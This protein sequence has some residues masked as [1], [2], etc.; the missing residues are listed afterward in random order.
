M[1]SSI[2]RSWPRASSSAIASA[3]A[4]NTRA[5]A[6]ARRRGGGAANSD[7]CVDK[8][9]VELADQ[10]ARVAD[11]LLDVADPPAQPRHRVAARAL[12]RVDEVARARRRTCR[13]RCGRAA[14]TRRARTTGASPACASSWSIAAFVV[15]ASRIALA[16]RDQLVDHVRR[17]S[18]SCRCPAAPTRTRAST[19]RT[20]GPPRAGSRRAP[21]D[22][23]RAP[24]ARAPAPP[25]RT[26][27][28]RAAPSRTPSSAVASRSYRNHG[29]TTSAHG[30]AASTRCSAA[31][32][33]R[34]SRDALDRDALLAARAAAART[35]CP[36]RARS[37]AARSCS[38]ARRGPRRARA[39]ISDD[40]AAS[41]IARSSPSMPRLNAATNLREQLVRHYSSIG[42]ARWRSNIRAR[43]AASS[44]GTSGP[45][46]RCAPAKPRRPSSVI[47]GQSASASADSGV[48]AVAT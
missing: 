41:R 20:A 43:S 48:S 45:S 34:P 13:R 5:S 25:C 26:A 8:A 39:R 6:A 11:L 42:H 21:R 22:R 24:P 30:A 2:A 47:R 31:I 44:R 9:G 40:P 3:A 27:S 32:V 18:P 4:S 36:P 37:P 38:A 12:P 16:A 7:C 10:R 29:A 17:A 15:D 23:A 35:P 19:P 14:R 33:T 28:A 46:S 1:R